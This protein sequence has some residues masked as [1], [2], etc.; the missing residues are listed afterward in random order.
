MKLLSFFIFYIYSSSSTVQC[1]TKYISCYHFIFYMIN[2]MELS[3]PYINFFNIYIRSFYIYEGTP[4]CH[5][6]TCPVGVMLW[7]TPCGNLYW[8]IKFPNLYLFAFK[9]INM[10]SLE[11]THFFSISLAVW[12][13][14][15]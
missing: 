4:I 13:R 5:L 12:N 11:F 2:I 3:R 14:Q 9:M 6:R 8:E 10:F 7:D 15:V 1:I